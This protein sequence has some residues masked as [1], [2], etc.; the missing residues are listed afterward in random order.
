MNKIKY[1]P[2]CRKQHDIKQNKCECGYEFVQVEEKVDATVQSSNT[3][4]IVDNVPLWI[5]TFLAFIT[6]SITGWIHFVKFREDYPERSKA[7]KRGAISFYIFAGVCL[8]IYG[9]Y[10]ILAS[11]GKIV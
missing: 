11:Q 10:L 7:A 2:V 1:C 3:K 4:V 8:L 9:L 6:I 5:W